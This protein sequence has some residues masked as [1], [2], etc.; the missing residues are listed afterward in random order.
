MDAKDAIIFQQLDVIRSMTEN[1]LR[2]V[3]D[4]FWGAPKPAP[5]NVEGSPHPAA[6]ADQPTSVSDATSNVSAPAQDDK[7]SAEAPPET[8][9]DLK[10]ELQSY[11]G[12][13]RIKRE[14]NNLINMV[15][16]AKL[17]AE[18][19]LPDTDLSLHMVFSG[20]PGTGK[21]M[22]ARLMARI[23]K[24]LGILSKG[25]L[26][27]V[28]RSGLVAGY[29]GQTAIKTS[30]VVK[31]ALGGVLFID[32]AYAL[33]QNRGENDFGQ[34]AIDTLLKAMED[35]RAD[36]VVIVAGYDGLMDEFIHSNPGLESRF[37]RFLHF[38]DYTTD[39]MVAIF[40]MQT[41]KGAYTLGDD[42]KAAVRRYIEAQNTNAISFGNARGVRNLFEKVLVNQ[43][44]RLAAL[45]GISR[46]QLMEITVSDIENA[47]A[48]DEAEDHAKDA[49]DSSDAAPD[50]VALNRQLDAL[51][52]GLAK[53]PKSD[54]D[55]PV[56]PGAS[57]PEISSEPETPAERAAS[58]QP[59][60]RV[61]AAID[62][63]MAET[64]KAT[65][66]RLNV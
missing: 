49:R 3:G 59:Q 29:V 32:E 41:K 6:P 54:S 27:E 11:I 12:L 23:Y 19:G 58:S 47:R 13:A 51:T 15:T 8:I 61:G 5:R 25:Q 35:N 10:G 21:T 52:S 1:N 2:R 63:N 33:T 16:V 36:L 28:D 37:N 44:N 14:V 48:E 18:H 22:I 30:D 34:E 38:D 4:D 31:T 60:A 50:F 9:E 65:E 53:E 62:P 43:A 42:A 55:A 7:A 20:N 40:E 56:F 26:I 24:C 46:E 17:R 66:D 64:T 45:P 39:E 57:E